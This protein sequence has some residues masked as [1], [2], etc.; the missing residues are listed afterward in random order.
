[1]YRYHVSYYDPFPYQ[2]SYATN[3]WSEVLTLLEK[4]GPVQVHL[5]NSIRNRVSC[6]FCTDDD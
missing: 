6:P 4:F 5:H 2:Q 1:M 3:D